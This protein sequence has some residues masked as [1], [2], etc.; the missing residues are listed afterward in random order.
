MCPLE[1]IAPQ[2]L[3]SF[4]MMILILLGWLN[5]RR[6]LPATKHC[7]VSPKPPHL[8]DT[9]FGNSRSSPI[10]FVYRRSD[11]FYFV[12]NLGLMISIIL[13]VPVSVKKSIDLFRNDLITY[14]FGINFIRLNYKIF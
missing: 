13:S 9:L 14:L 6:L 2:Q 3:V 1:K 7:S 10:C 12:F 8:R 4:S 11:I 5:H